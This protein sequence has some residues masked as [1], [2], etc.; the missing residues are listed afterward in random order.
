MAIAENSLAPAKAL[1]GSYDENE[2]ALR[3]TAT[4]G[5]SESHVGQVGGNTKVFPATAFTLDTSAYSSGDV[6][7][8]ALEFDNAMRVNDGT[9]YLIALT[10]IDEDDQGVAMDVYV[11]DA[12]VSLGT[13]NSAPNISDANARNILGIISVA[14]TDWKDLGGARVAH[15]KGLAMPVSAGTGTK[16]IWLACVNGTGTPT[17]TESG[18]RAR[19]AFERN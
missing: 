9:G 4:I 13:K 3:T 8:D 11:M 18:L 1:A 7:T 19:P 14:T 15:L 16:K 17:F 6:L 5:A 2:G 10:L 12:N